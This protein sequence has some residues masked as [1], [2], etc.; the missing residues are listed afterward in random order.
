M[1]FERV[2]SQ[3]QVTRL[4][5]LLQSPAALTH[6]QTGT[7][8][9]EGVSVVTPLKKVFTFSFDK[10]FLVPW[11]S[12]VF[13]KTCSFF[14]S[15]SPANMTPFRL[16][17]TPRQ[18]DLC[19]RYFRCTLCAESSGLNLQLSECW[20]QR[21]STLKTRFRHVLPR[22]IEAGCFTAAESC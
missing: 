11:R 8:D 17:K 5:Q 14:H 1:S 18:V 7:D 22:V 19:H 9:E 12:C 21:F 10:S 13:D 2:V 3:P 15:L 6:L 4:L 16:K 20:A